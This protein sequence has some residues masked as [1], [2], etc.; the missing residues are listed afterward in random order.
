MIEHVVQAGAIRRRMWLFID[1]GLTTP[2]IMVVGCANDWCARK[3]IKLSMARTEARD[4]MLARLITLTTL[5]V[6]RHDKLKHATTAW[7]ASA[8]HGK[9]N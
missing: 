1:A 8:C 5:D 6:D 4:Q 7:M 2:G 3:P 9:R